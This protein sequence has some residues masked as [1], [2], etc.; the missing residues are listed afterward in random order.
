VVI[1]LAR[2]GDV[3]INHG[4]RA[5]GHGSHTRTREAETPGTKGTGPLHR[6]P[7]FRVVVV[8]EDIESIAGQ[9]A[10]DDSEPS[11]FVVTYTDGDEE[12]R[13]GTLVEAGR[14]ADEAGLILVP[15]HGKAVRWVRNPEL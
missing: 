2:I 1:A 14:L 15:T 9:V 10:S 4:L 8:A 6:G 3:A 12:H 5:R 13:E 7:R 11:W